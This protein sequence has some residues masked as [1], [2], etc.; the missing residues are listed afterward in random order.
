MTLKEELE[1]LDELFYDATGVYEDS[2]IGAGDLSLADEWRY[3]IGD[4]IG[5]V[6]SMGKA[7]AETYAAE[8]SEI[9]EAMKSFLEH[10]VIDPELHT[11][12]HITRLKDILEGRLPSWPE[13]EIESTNDAGQELWR[14]MG[15][16]RRATDEYVSLLRA[17]GM[18]ELADRWKDALW[19]M[20]WEVWAGEWFLG[21]VHSPPNEGHP[22]M[23]RRFFQRALHQARRDLS[24]PVARLKDALK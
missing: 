1:R 14:L 22:D 16:L 11:R 13:G 21:G 6:T 15:Q 18:E 19:K 10:A 3:N 2:L 24:N 4:L 9:P 7:L 23:M 8:P 12:G 20:T 17:A 5:D